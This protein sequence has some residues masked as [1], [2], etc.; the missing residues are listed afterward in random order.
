MAAGS[1]GA[2]RE[3]PRRSDRL[4][5]TSVEAGATRRRAPAWD[6]GLVAA[7]LFAFV[8]LGLPDGMLGVAWPS[9]R[10]GFGL[11]LAALGEL[12]VAL[13]IGYLCVT[14]ITGRCLRRFGTGTVLLASA[15]A[16]SAG[17]ALFATSPVWGGLVGAA[18]LLGV[19]GGGVDAALNTVVALDGESRLMNLLHGCYGIGAACGPLVVTAALVATSTWRSAYVVLMVCEA[20]LAVTWVVVRNRFPRFAPAT[21]DTSREQPTAEQGR[22]TESGTLP[23]LR[24]MLVL[25]FGVFFFAAALEAT[26]AS[27]AAS[28]LR[29][30]VGLSAVWAGFAV[31]VFEA[32]LTL[33][34]MAAAWLSPRWIPERIARLGIVGSV[35]GSAA[36]WADVGPGATVLALAVLGFALGPVFPA[37]MLLTPTRLGQRRAVHAVGWQLAAAAVGGVGVAAAV[38]VVLQAVG[39]GGFGPVL[40][41]LALGLG[42][43]VLA[44]E[45]KAAPLLAVA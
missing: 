16:G 1:S 26:V 18:T 44:S 36:L 4:L 37:L 43:L 9:V 34:R 19:A 45:R 13:L 35:I 24:G 32:G 27:W 23:V 33:G 22:G 5:V 10:H 6:T 30:P 15:V 14:S 41:V 20:L 3:V 25:S 7:S 11:P 28:Y 38:G 42:S 8:V 12:L 40:V 17:A 2:G 21:D 39:L 29:G 31:F